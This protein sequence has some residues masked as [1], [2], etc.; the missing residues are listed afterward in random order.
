MMKNMIIAPVFFIVLFVI[1]LATAED[2]RESSQKLKDKRQEILNKASLEKETALKDAAEAIKKISA[3]KKRLLSVIKKI[4]A[5][6]RAIGNENKGLEK[7]D[8][9]LEKIEDDLF[10]KEARLDAMVRELTGVV[11]VSA[12]N[13]D[14]VL[15]QSLQS[16]LDKDRIEKIKPVL[17]KSRF[18]G[19]DDIGMIIDMFFEEIKRSGEIRIQQGIIVD[20]NGLEVAADI[21]TVGNFTAAYRLKGETGFLTYSPQSQRLFALSRLPSWLT[22]KKISKYMSG[23]RDD[24]SVDLSGGAALRQLT[25]KI[26]LLGQIRKGG[27]IVWPILLIGIVSLIIAVER[28]MFLRKTMIN[29]DKMMNDVNSLAK[30]NK[31]DKCM[32]ICQKQ[33]ERPVPRVLL[34]GINSRRMDRE[35]MENVLQET[36]LGEIPRLEKFLPTLGILAAIA[37][38]LGLLGTVTGMINTFHVITLYGTGDPKMMSGGISEALVTTMLGLG[39]AIPIMLFYTFLSRTVEKIISQME[40][41]A[42]ALTNIVFRDKGVC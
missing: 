38:L 23:R 39:V 26:S 41:K 6:N 8:A 10:K 33:S 16:A 14:S 40:E 34:S 28:F 42:V 18:P 2:M 21:L 27:P 13:L 11:R 3:D 1:S 32:E 31:W 35:G 9:R 22:S 19:M 24:L 36:I 29:A 15:L 37:P 12:K 20:R 17:N 30:D 4:E 7:D 5:E 25:H